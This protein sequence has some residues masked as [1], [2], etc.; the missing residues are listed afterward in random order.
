ML[1]NTANQEKTL[2][3]YTTEHQQDS[4]KGKWEWTL[5]WE[6]VNTVWNVRVQFASP[7]PNQNRTKILQKE[8]KGS[9]RN[10]KTNKQTNKMHWLK[11]S[12]V[13]C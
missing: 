5:H 1:Y 3:T 12:K 11:R 10:E 8:N 9:I 6:Q 13:W 7:Y 2:L 4:V